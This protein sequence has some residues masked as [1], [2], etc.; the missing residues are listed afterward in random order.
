MAMRKTEL[1]PF[2]GGEADFD[3]ERGSHWV[4]CTKC[5]ARTRKCESPREAAEAWNLRPSYCG[6]AILKRAAW[7]DDEDTDALDWRS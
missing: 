6:N 4:V 7:R 1:C 2:C 3:G 5:G